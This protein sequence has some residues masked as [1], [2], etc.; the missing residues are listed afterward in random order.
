ML[1]LTLA[2]VFLAGLL[3]STHCVAMCGGISTALASAPGAGPGGSGGV[4]SWLPLCYQ[5]GRV[6]GYAALGALVGALGLVTGAA[7]GVTLARWANVLRLATSMVVIVIGLDIALARSGRLRWLRA[8]ERLGGA[9]WRSLLRW[10]RGALPTR[11]MAR[12]L[13]LG[14]LWGW[15]PCGLVYSALLAAAA[16]G[17][18]LSGA[19]TMVAFGCGT[20]PAMLLLNHA[21]ARI[22]RPNGALASVLGAVL[23][24]CGIWTAAMPLMDLSGH[25][26]H[27]MA[28][29]ASAPTSMQ[30]PMPMP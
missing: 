11:P 9:L 24:A 23:V 2:T 10:T 28:M 3:G 21:G 27:S 20:L 30:M 16:A 26:H 8:P 13:A 22:L 6:L 5:I 25:P 19:A 12:A 29:P 14:V 18:A 1:E 17:N 15:M 7:F 4:R